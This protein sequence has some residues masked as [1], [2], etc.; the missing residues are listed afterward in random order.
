[1][2]NTSTYIY[3]MFKDIKTHMSVYILQFEPIYGGDTAMDNWW[4]P[5]CSGA[6]FRDI[7]RY[8]ANRITNI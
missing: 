6:R 8:I 2:L 5:E 3:N 1:M 7:C 4:G